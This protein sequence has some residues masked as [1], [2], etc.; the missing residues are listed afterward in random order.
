MTSPRSVSSSDTVSVSP[1]VAF[2]AFTHEM[3]LCWVRGPINF[4]DS[5]RAVSMV[6]E[7]GV[8]GRILEVY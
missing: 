6:C 2:S 3:N 8:G 4:F 5:A 7:P 1:E